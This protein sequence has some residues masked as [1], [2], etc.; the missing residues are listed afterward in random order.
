MRQSGLYE[1]ATGVIG[2]SFQEEFR[3]RHAASLGVQQQSRTTDGLSYS[4]TNPRRVLR[5]HCWML[6]SQLC[7]WTLVDGSKFTSKLDRGTYFKAGDSLL[8][9]DPSISS[10]AKHHSLDDRNS[11][12][13]IQITG[14]KALSKYIL[15][16]SNTKVS[17]Y[18]TSPS[19]V[20]GRD[21]QSPDTSKH[22]KHIVLPLPE[23]W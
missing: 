7:V 16:T 20:T 9:P 22:L 12:N 21:I 17:Q 19:T 2:K 14:W 1:V 3:V 10:A 8:L 6:Y 4:R 23:R 18:R 15:H 13:S 11:T 5:S